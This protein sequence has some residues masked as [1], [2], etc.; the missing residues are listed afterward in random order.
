MLESPFNKVAVRKLELYQKETLAQ[1]FSCD[2][3]EIFQST[4]L[5]K[6][7][8]GDCFCCSVAFSTF[9]ISHL[10]NNGSNHQVMFRKCLFLKSTSKT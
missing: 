6:T 3:F 8:P 5:Y 7:P 10:T 4:F 2:F 1:V 9:R